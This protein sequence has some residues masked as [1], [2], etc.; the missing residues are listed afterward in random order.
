MTGVLWAA[1][2]AAIT[3]PA[4]PLAIVRAALHQYEDGPALAPDYVFAPG[5]T[6]FF[7]FLV[8]GY[9][10]SPE[11]RIE[12][13]CRIDAVDAEGTLL[14][15]PFRQEIKVELA[16]ED[17]EWLPKVRHSVPTPPLGDPGTH[18]IRIL[19]RDLLA[20]A[21]TRLEIPFRAG[22][23]QVAPSDTLIARN[24]R[25]LRSEEDRDPLRVAAYR[26]GDAL[27]ARFEIRGY[28]YAEKNQVHVEYGL[29]VLGPGGQSLYKEPQAAVEQSSSFYP[30]RYL[31]GSLSLNL[32]A[33]ARPGEYTIVLRLRDLIGG[34]ESESRHG[35]KIE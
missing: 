21:E 28:K 25:F 14:A 19:V 3:A 26:P 30:R 35:F 32:Q 27:W 1:L 7:D 33:N 16:P 29:E 2:L 4:P 9:K 15:E 20:G 31:P 24:F 5:E 22:G 34:Q 6:A 11:Q 18:R 13:E 8:Q 12:L 23:R 10:V 17:K